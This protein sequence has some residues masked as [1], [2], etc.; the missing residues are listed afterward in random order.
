MMKRVSYF[1]PFVALAALLVLTSCSEEKRMAKGFVLPKGEI[2]AGKTA[3]SELKCTLCHSV[4]G[5]EFPEI[6]SGAGFELG[7]EVRRIKTYGELAT[8]V[9]DPTHDVNPKFIATRPAYNGEKPSTPMPSYNSNMTVRQLSDIVIFLHS[10][11]QEEGPDFT[12]Y[13][14]LY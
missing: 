13:P 4:A 11:F 5:V 2:E 6:E 9:I 14:F 7:G 12:D 3:F 1:P 8:A 10:R